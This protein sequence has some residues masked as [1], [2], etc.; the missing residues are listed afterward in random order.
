MSIID[1]LIRSFI[2]KKTAINCI[3]YNNDS[4]L[5]SSNTGTDLSVLSL[6]KNYLI[7]EQYYQQ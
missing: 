2:L 7:Q 3:N 5:K 1:K 4:C 6:Y